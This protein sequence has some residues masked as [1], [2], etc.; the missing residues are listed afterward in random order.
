[1]SLFDGAE[2][3]NLVS[4][5]SLDPE[6]PSEP[7]EDLEGVAV[8]VRSS[9]DREVVCTPDSTLLGVPR[10]VL[11]SRVGVRVPSYMYSESSSSSKPITCRHKGAI[12]FERP[13]K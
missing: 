4:E 8:V 13:L 2:W 12:D 3:S 10:V 9:S 7:K 6:A 1:M 11:A 5:V